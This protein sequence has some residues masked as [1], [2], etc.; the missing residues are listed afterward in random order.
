MSKI[1]PYQSPN[2]ES[3]VTDSASLKKPRIARNI[4]AICVLYVIFGFL[5]VL[6]GIGILLDSKGTGVA[7]VV[8]WAV[9]LG[10]SVG[11]VS[12]IG[13]IRKK[14]WGIPVCQIVSA[15]YLLGFPIGTFLGGYFLFNIGKVKSEFQ[16]R[17]GASQ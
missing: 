8:G 1:N 11:L 6:G 17:S 5:A 7:P 16:P 14:S 15:L 13:V 4:R 3:T 2:E 10:G 9:L 12:A